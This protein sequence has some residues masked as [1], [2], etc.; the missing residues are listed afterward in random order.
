M[1]RSHNQASPYE[2]SNRWAAQLQS[3]RL[4]A[5]SHSL[6]RLLHHARNLCGV[7]GLWN[8]SAFEPGDRGDL[9]ALGKAR[10]R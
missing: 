1:S 2:S 6:K 10:R 3:P 8:R 9:T 7:R 5:V 4:K